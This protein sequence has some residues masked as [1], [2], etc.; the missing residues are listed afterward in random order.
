MAKLT[1]IEGIGLSIAGKLKKTGVGSTDTLLKH[2]CDRK[3]RAEVAK[4]CGISPTMVLKFANHA[5]LMRIK[6]IGGEYSELLEASGVDTVRELAR[7]DATKLHQSMAATNKRKRLV[8]Q[9]PSQRMINGWVKRAK[10]MKPMV[11]H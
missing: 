9:L 8:R 1:T 7:R 10:R 2:C 5:D 11:F 4:S 6:G 3:G